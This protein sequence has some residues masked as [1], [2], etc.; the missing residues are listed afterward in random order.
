[1]DGRNASMGTSRTVPAL[2]MTVVTVTY[3]LFAPEGL[4][5]FTC[6]AWGYDMAYTVALTAGLTVAAIFLGLFANL[7]R[8]LSSS[9]LNLES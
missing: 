7:L 9:R 4:G 3:I 2:L 1:M 6:P 5:A 8:G